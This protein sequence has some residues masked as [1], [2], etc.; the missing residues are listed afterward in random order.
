MK[1]ILDVQNVSVSYG[2]TKAVEDVSFKISRGEFV[3]LAGPN[4][5]G[6]STLIKAILSLLPLSSGKIT[7]FGRDLN[8]FSDF[9]KIGFLPQNS[10]GINQL[11]PA[12]VEE[13]VLL[14]LL[15]GK[16]NPKRI[17]SEDKQ[18]VLEILG[19]LG[20]ASL[21]KKMLC[22]LSGGQQ[23][24]VFLARALVCSPELLILDE[25]SSALDPK[26]RERFFELAEK[27][28]K[29]DKTTIILIT[30]DTGYI[31]KYAGKLLYLDRKAV[32]FGKISEFCP[33]GEINSCFE[34]SDKHI[35]WHQHD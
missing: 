20:I 11:F 18:K 31:G 22:E 13:V 16:K 28:N 10:S 25:P 4:G 19:K 32:F 9:S 5:G 2:R 35:I 24:K 6:K 26:S 1:N 14:G 15:V 12:S 27:M 30:H 17:T 34:K 21:G 33:S 7:L 8:S 29:Q 3:G 23:Q